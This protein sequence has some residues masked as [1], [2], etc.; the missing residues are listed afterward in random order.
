MSLNFKMKHKI[1]INVLL[2]FFIIFPC[3]ANDILNLYSARQEVL[4][5]PLLNYLKMNIKLKLI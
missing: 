4:M 2:S 1:T 5:R 3:L